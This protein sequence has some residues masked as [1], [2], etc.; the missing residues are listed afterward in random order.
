[1]WED[2]GNTGD[3]PMRDRSKASRW[4]AWDI[5][6]FCYFVVGATFAILPGYFRILTP[7]AIII[8]AE[9]L[10]NKGFF[11]WPKYHSRHD[12]EVAKKIEASQQRL[13]EE[14]RQRKLRGENLL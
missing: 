12:A 14:Q 11:D 3:G 1:M 10:W 7:I 2:A 5:G 13:K 8:L 6:L 4:D 9:Y